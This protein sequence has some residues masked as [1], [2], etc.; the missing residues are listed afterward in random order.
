MFPLRVQF[1]RT[2]AR[3]RGIGASDGVDLDGDVDV[4]DYNVANGQSGLTLGHSVP[5]AAPT[6]AD[7]GNRMGYAGYA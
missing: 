4:N 2:L 3:L 7:V 6:T 5:S 1:G